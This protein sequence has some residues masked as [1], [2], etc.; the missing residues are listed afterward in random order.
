M[1]VTKMNEMIN[2][3]VMLGMINETVEAGVKMIP[4]A[5]LD[6]S[7]VGRAGDTVTI[8][9]WEY[10]GDAK[11]VAEGELLEGD[12]LQTN[13]K[14]FKIK[15]ASKAVELTEES[16]NSGYGDPLGTTSRQLGK[17]IVQKVDN[18]AY[19]ALLSAQ[20]LYDNSNA[21]INY[22]GVVDANNTFQEEDDSEKIMFIHPN[23]KSQL[24]KDSTF[25]D[26]NK[27]GWGTDV[28]M[29]GQIGKV[30][31]TRIIVSRKV[32]KFD[33]WYSFATQEDSGAV[34]VT[35]SNIDEVKATLPNVEVGNYVVKSTT[36]VYFNPI[37]KLNGDELLDGSEE[38]LTIFLKK[39]TELKNEEDV[40]RGTYYFRANKFYTVAITNQTKVV[41]AKFKTK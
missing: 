16:I 3:E 24:L 36:P 11:D 20:I 19:T 31:N 40:K 30:N 8:P 32:Q 39:D 12:L 25:T 28:I 41:L 6:N 35:S 23:Q 4:F 34:E 9:S 37:V 10:I 13:T 18:D 38:A 27:Y 17:A 26:Q 15:K 5:K 2:P 21:K 22:D 29:K 7:L 14:Q 33:E 1:A